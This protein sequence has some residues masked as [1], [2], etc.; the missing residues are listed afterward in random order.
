MDGEPAFMNKQNFRDYHRTGKEI[1]LILVRED[2]C[3]ET[4]DK[5]VAD[6]DLAKP[7]KGIALLFQLRT[8]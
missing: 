1:V 8:C 2:K 7:G 4:L 5:I 3:K 6:V